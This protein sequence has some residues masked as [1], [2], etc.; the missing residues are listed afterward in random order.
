MWEDNMFLIVTGSMYSYTMFKTGYI[1]TNSSVMS[2]PLNALEQGTQIIQHLVKA[3]SYFL[4]N[5]FCKIHSNSSTICELN[6]SYYT[7]PEF[8][9]QQH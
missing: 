7:W 1:P 3:C 4:L 5:L 8:S 9:F 2:I 6:R